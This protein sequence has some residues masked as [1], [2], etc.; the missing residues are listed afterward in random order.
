MPQASLRSSTWIRPT[1]ARPWL[2]LSPRQA[3]KWNAPKNTNLRAYS[4][5]LTRLVT[6]CTAESEA[7]NAPGVRVS[8]QTVKLDTL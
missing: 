3:E 1:F 8:M 5:S 4:D 2:G 6:V 7:T